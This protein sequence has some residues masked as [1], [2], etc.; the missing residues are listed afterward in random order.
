MITPKRILVIRRDNIGDLV[1]TTPLFD[2]LRRYFPE[3]R[4]D[5]LVNSY[6]APVLAGNPSLDTIYHY[7]KA[8]HKQPGQSRL[9]VYRD[10]GKLLWH[11]RRCRF[12]YV[13]L[14]GQANEHARQFARWIGAHHIIGLTDSVAPK[15]IDYP[16]DSHCVKDKHEVMQC[17]ALL[18]AF[19]I[20]DTPGPLR[21]FPNINLVA[22]FQAHVPT[23]KTASARHVAVHISAREPERHWPLNHFATLCRYIARQGNIPWLFWS[24]GT[25][26]NPRHPGDDRRAQELLYLTRD[27]TSLYP[28][29]T[30]T[31]DE[32]IAALSL[33]DSIVCSDGGVL[34][35]AAA[36]GKPIVALFENRSDKTLRWYPWRVPYR[37]VTPQTRDVRDI[38]VESV[39]TALDQLSAETLLPSES[40]C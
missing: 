12:D 33:C 18:T 5:A 8:K 6:N 15:A 39:L 16:I 37:M 35:C 36:L 23:R 20:I 26:D 29:A 30:Q 11:L 25:A 21:V 14:P 40:Y 7:T 34:H 10:T 17:H 28:C 3:A 2:T 22:S 1:C 27:I 31:L 19:G 4:I 32:L 9:A 13:L 24:P 38:A